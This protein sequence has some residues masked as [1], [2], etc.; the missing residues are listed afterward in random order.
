MLANMKHPAPKFKAK[1]RKYR[2]VFEKH[3]PEKYILEKDW[4]Q[5]KEHM[6]VPKG[7]GPS[8]R[9]IKHPLLACFTRRKS[10]IETCH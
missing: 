8:V 7:S 5:Q 9:R 3:I 1:S 4:S 2:G 10:S 6:Q